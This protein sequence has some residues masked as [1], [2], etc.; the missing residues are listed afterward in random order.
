V[1]MKNI[2]KY[3]VCIFL[4]CSFFE[5]KAGLVGYGSSSKPLSR[6]DVLFIKEFFENNFLLTLLNLLYL[7]PFGYWVKKQPLNS[8]I[9]LYQIRGNFTRF[10]L[11]LW[12]ERIENE[13]GLRL[14]K[15]RERVDLYEKKARML[16]FKISYYKSIL[17]NQVL[18][19]SFGKRGYKTA[20]KRMHKNTKLLI[21][22]QLSQ[23]II[24]TILSIKF[25]VI[26][27][28]SLIGGFFLGIATALFIGVVYWVLINYI[29][30]LIFKLIIEILKVKKGHAGY[31]HIVSAQLRGFYGAFWSNI[32]IPKK[33]LM[34]ITDVSIK[35]GQTKIVF[36]E[37]KGS[38]AGGSW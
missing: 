19:N 30:T 5:A 23:V 18:S 6:D 11:N 1:I 25:W 31:W 32:P 9:L 14:L 27:L 12:I 3:S 21:F 33:A 24:S 7:I 37:F 2:I 29:F 22:G 17:T 15:L 26:E 8:E 34:L 36:K 16:G 10:N 28:N 20:F 13:R 38:G 35:N 4:F